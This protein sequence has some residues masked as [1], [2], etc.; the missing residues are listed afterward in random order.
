MNLAPNTILNQNCYRIIK[1]IGQGGFG[2]TYL[3][4]EIGYFR[5][6]GF[7]D[8]HYVSAKVPEQVVIK[9][10]YYNDYCQRDPKT[11]LVNISNTDKKI[12]FNKLVENQLEEGKKLRSLNHANIVRTRDI[13]KENDTAYMVMD[14]VES[15]DLEELL[16]KA[17]KL[18]KNKAL[19]YI[20][21]VLSALTHIHDRS[22]LHL[23]I[24]PSN[25]LIKKDT[26][27]AIVIDFGASQS[28][29]NSG[30][31]IG[32]TSQLVAGMTKHYAPNEQADI[33][34]LKHF[35]ATFD[36][37][38]TGA[39]LYHL[40]TGQKPP[41]S[42]LL[43]TGREKLIPPSTFVN[44]NGVSDYLDAI[45]TK[46]LAPMFHSRFKSAIEFE[47]AL[48][49]ESEY[50]QQLNQINKLLATKNYLQAI[51]QIEIVENN[52]LS[53][54]TLEKLRK[55]TENELHKESK[56][57]E[58]QLFFTKGLEWLG[59][60][61]YNLALQQFIKASH[62]F[63]DKIEALEKTKYCKEQIA[64][65][66]QRKKIAELL[67][68][69]KDNI[70]NNKLALAKINITDILKLEP[71]NKD[72]LYLQNKIKLEED[73]IIYADPFEREEETIILREKAKQT[74]KLE[75]KNIPDIKS[76]PKKRKSLI[77]ILVGGTILTIVAFI[78]L[79]PKSDNK[80]EIPIVIVDSILKKE[81]TVLS[82]FNVNQI[83]TAT[84]KITLENLPNSKNSDKWRAEFIK[85]FNELASKESYSSPDQ[86]HSLYNSLYKY[87]PANAVLERNQIKERVAFWWNKMVEAESIEKKVTEVENKKQQA[88]LLISEANS[89]FKKESDKALNKYMQAN[90]LVPG[91][92]IDG[93]NNFLSWAKKMYENYN[94]CNGCKSDNDCKQFVIEKL[95]KALQINPSGSEAKQIINCLN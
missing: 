80:T 47:N 58:Y 18:D 4:D 74:E 10:L 85:Q 89:I 64:K 84:T 38:A 23:D 81:D 76:N 21:Q 86:L 7:G 68:N 65:E 37:Y 2:I 45:I 11:G 83:D 48:A 59:R 16:N 91:I 3:A 8:I 87:V 35:D 1:V 51:Q 39:T 90:S 92:A 24:K 67:N 33:D 78:L 94:G 70:A 14:Y 30:K 31:I 52:F 75:N 12:E 63:P 17:G 6:T 22:K 71:A 72:A 66:E 82:T 25:V 44:N 54:I 62:V 27:D 61:E 29:D 50:L 69:A 41:L 57:K 34:N 20:T 77:Y 19:K 55:A 26:D 9:E 13:F 46:A 95:N 93:Y 15:T 42:S 53:T 49:K 60:K 5:N 32:K 40:I 28:Y 36:T 43:S 73:N 88:Q 79:S 56:I